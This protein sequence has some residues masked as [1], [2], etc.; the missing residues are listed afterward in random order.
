MAPDLLIALAGV[1]VGVALT[2]SLFL[3]GVLSRR[4]PGRVRL[5]QLSGASATGIV[6]ESPT[7]TDSPSPLAKRLSAIAP[8]SPKELSILRRRL[9]SAGYRSAN[10]AFTFS[11]AKLVLAAVVSAGT[12]T[13]LGRSGLLYVGALGI[14]GFML[15][16][17]WLAR[18]TKKRQN[19]IRNGL[20]D[21]LDLFIVCLEAG[22]SLDQAIVKASEE[23]GITYPPLADELRMITIEIRAGKPRLEAF[24]NF[25]ARTR[26]DD[27]RSLT[28][29]LIQTDR[30]GTSL[31]QA[32]RIHADSARTQRRQR[33]E[34][35]AA[36]LGVKLVFPLVFFLFPALYVV[37][38]GPAAI[39]II[40]VFMTP[41]GL[42]Q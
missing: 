36:K 7:L 12:F 18:Q 27:V 11:A 26:V 15:P 38:L 1:F 8:K 20:P 30:F 35:K 2:T 6:L 40:R 5:Q 13:M 28:A 42:G 24:K 21:A 39:K 14:A 4:A 22:S 33:A 19:I 3:S 31:A 9:G 23:L 41:G 17:L 32:L 10:A 37:I 25:A 16:D 34:E 29:M